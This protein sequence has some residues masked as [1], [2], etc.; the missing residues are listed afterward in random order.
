[1]SEK[2]PLGKEKKSNERGELSTQINMDVCEVVASSQR[3]TML[4][5][6]TNKPLTALK[7]RMKK[8]K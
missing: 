6:L 5:S 7:I 3:M 8:L 2:D 1:M 4:C